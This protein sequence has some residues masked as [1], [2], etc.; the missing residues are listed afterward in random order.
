MAKR[1]S[2]RPLKAIRPD[3]LLFGAT[4]AL[5]IIGIIMVTSASLPI[6]ES[7]GEDS[8]HYVKRHLMFLAMG[9]I[10]A[11]ITVFIPIREM[12][13]LSPLAF[14]AA[15]VLLGLVWIPGLGHTVNGSTRW[16]NLGISKFQVGEAV[17]LSMVVF[18]AGYMAR[19]EHALRERLLP[20]L[21][22]L[23]AAGLVAL[24]LLLQPDF[25]SAV[26]ILGLTLALVWLAGA[27]WLH[28]GSL[29]LLTAP[30]VAWAAMSESYRLR[31]LTSFLD[32]WADPFNDGFQL[33]QA[34]I[35]IGRGEWFGVGLGGSVQKLFYLPEAHTDFILAVTAEELGLMGVAGIIALFVLLV[36]RSLFIGLEAMQ[37][38]R[39]FAGFLAWGV[40]LWLGLQAFVS[41]GVNLGMLPTKGITLPLVSSGGSSVLTTCVA[42]AIVLRVSHELREPPAKT[43]KKRAKKTAKNG[44]STRRARA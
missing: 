31:R 27:R 28:L 5:I 39:R 14:L 6:A 21:L 25:G 18:L 7:H 38:G 24:L 32:P 1:V 8:F 42:I 44:R 33:T 40:G 36:G 16:I 2:N 15:V 37:A 4:L 41:I 11:L 19:C 29:A 9:T 3:P 35:A 22:P 13:R 30:V 34:L 23:V 26:L 12:R 43:A 17:K 10:G 20:A